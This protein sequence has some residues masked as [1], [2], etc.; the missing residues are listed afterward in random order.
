MA[1]TITEEVRARHTGRLASSAKLL[2]KLPRDFQGD[3]RG[4]S[5]GLYEVLERISGLSGE[6]QW[7]FKGVTMRFNEGLRRGCG[8]W[9]FQD[10][11]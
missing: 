2:R 1:V 9:D 5:E 11:S 4:V 10:S 8:F 6:C 7:A 3:F